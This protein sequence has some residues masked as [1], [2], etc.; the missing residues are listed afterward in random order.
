MALE[1]NCVSTEKGSFT[2]SS[3]SAQTI[4]G[5]TVSLGSSADDQIASV[6]RFRSGAADHHPM[7]DAED[8]S[9]TDQATTLAMDTLQSAANQSQHIHQS[10]GRLSEFG[11][12]SS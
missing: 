4:T 9:G 12:T 3:G 11:W 1:K 6:R 10:H 2:T 7:D 8:E 5:K